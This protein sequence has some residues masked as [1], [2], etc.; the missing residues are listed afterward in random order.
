MQLTLVTQLVAGDPDAFAALYDRLGKRLYATAVQLN[1]AHQ[2]AEDIVHDLFVELARHRH[3]LAHVKNLDA[4]IFTMLRN[5]VS[6]LQRRKKTGLKA[7]LQ[8]ASD[9]V[10]RNRTYEVP[11]T[12]PDDDLSKALNLLPE[13]QRI[14]LILK[15]IF[16]LS[17][18]QI[19]S[20]VGIKM[21]TA[22]SR[23]RYAI[24]KLQSTLESEE[25]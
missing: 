11:P 9:H 12:L 2:E 4:Y 18:K 24:Q 10:V 20:V 1:C 13:P 23:Y 25:K 22:A 17:F 16:G 19:S 6:R 3:E 7:L 21:N 5:A 8:W 14:V 15:V